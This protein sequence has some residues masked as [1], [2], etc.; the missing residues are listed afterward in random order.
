MNEIMEMKA[1]MVNKLALM[2]MEHAEDMTMEQALGCVFN[3]DTY[4]KLMN[5]NT[6]LYYQSP[7]YVYA[8]LEQEL[9]QG[10]MN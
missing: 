4:Q 6:R 1:Y 7:G 9:K 10:K 8:Y 3:S 2:L 5:D